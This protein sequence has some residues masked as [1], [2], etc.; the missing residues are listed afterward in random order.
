ML[1]PKSSR[2]ISPLSRDEYGVRTHLN[3]QES[4]QETPCLIS[5]Y[6]YNP[7]HILHTHAREIDNICESA[8]LP[9]CVVLIINDNLYGLIFVLSYTCR[10]PYALLDLHMLESRLREKDF[11]LIKAKCKMINTQ[12]ISHV[13]IC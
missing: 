4:W 5:K 13:K 2:V 3:L 1:Y 9:P 7:L 12:V 11:S 10:C 8:W 6:K